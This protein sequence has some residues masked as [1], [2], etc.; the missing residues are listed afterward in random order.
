MLRLAKAKNRGSKK[1]ISE[2]A[3]WAAAMSFAFAVA[4]LAMPI[5]RAAATVSPDGRVYYGDQTNTALHFQN[6][7]FSFSFGAEQTFTHGASASFIAHTVAKA[8]P[9]RD[10]MM[11]GNLKVDGQLM[12]IKGV[13]GSDVNTDYSLAWTNPGTTG[14]QTCNSATEVDCTRAFDI[15][16]EKLSGRAMVV[17]ADTTNQKLYYCYWDGT[18]W[19]PQSSCTP[20][21]GTNDITLTANGR[22]DFVSLKGKGGS[23][24][25]L[26][27]V[28]IDVAGTHKVEA[29]RWDGSS[30][31]DHVDATSSTNASVNTLEAGQVFDV[32]WESLSGDALVVWGTTTAGSTKYKLLPSGSGTWG[33]EQ[34]GP[35]LVGANGIINT[36]Q[37][38]ADP[39]SDRIAFASTDSANDGNFGI[40]KADGSTVG[41]TMGTEDTTL[42]SDNPG[43]QYDD[44]AWQKTGSK[45]V[46]FGQTGSTTTDWEYETA[47]C[48]GSG[49]TFVGAPDASI[50]IPATVDDGTYVRL[51]PSPNTND[52][53]VLTGDIDRDLNADHWNG[54][55]WEATPAALEADQSPGTVDNTVFQGVSAAFAYIPYSPWTRNWRFYNGTDTTNT[56]TTALANENTT[57]TGFDGFAGKARLRFEVQELS[58]MG[59]TDA[60]KKLQYAYGAN[61]TPDTVE[62][63]PD[64]TWADVDNAGGSGIWRYVDCGGAGI[65]D[66]NSTLSA[67][68]LSGTPTAGWWTQDKSAAA[69]TNM[70]HS[71]LQL[72]ELEYSIEANDAPGNTTFYFRMYDVEQDK[73]VRREQDND[74]SNDCA[75]AVCK[76]PSITTASG[77]RTA[78]LM[79]GGNWFSGGSEQSFFWAQ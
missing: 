43:T 50:A 12:V 37:L 44:V 13:N 54:S 62:G 28:S 66:D 17:Y 78:D 67:T 11:V 27:G 23:N 42:E 70:D 22:P 33:S 49:C 21:N 14:A 76:Y 16:Y 36:M 1:V 32:E 57:P 4:L 8:A 52:I 38:D 59:Q 53:M 20:T 24:E 58:G 68:V 5:Y 7:T 31:T 41:W 39:V 25:I 60:R 72:R 48:T 74:G 63:D 26:L 2:I 46:W 30:W 34:T 9:T 77:A 69:G 71:A 40:W 73:V 61:C 47:T 45:A 64:C 51:T 55:A 19:G 3:K 15:A 29:F 65:C 75:T 35:A 56:P 79:R 6:N 18:S 10:E